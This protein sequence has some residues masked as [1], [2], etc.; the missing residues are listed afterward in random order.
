MKSNNKSHLIQKYLSDNI[1]DDEK[2]E[3]E[4]L[5]KSDPSFLKELKSKKR[6]FES[7][8]D[9]DFNA[10]FPKLKSAEEKYLMSKTKESLI[11]KKR[12]RLLILVVFLA[13]AFFFLWYFFL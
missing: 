7:A 13:I 10:F 4:N 8:G 1:S 6:L 3:V 2:K 9:E 11:Q 12:I 5:A